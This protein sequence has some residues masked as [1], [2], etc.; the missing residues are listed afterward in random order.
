MASLRFVQDD[1]GNDTK[2]ALAMFAKDGEEVPLE[3][4]CDCN[5]QV[6]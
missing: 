3:S 5:G 2:S 6:I 4:E 1:E